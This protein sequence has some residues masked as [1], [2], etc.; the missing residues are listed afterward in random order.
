[1]KGRNGHLDEDQIIAVVV[2]EE[3]L[4]EEQRRH[5]ETCPLCREEKAALASGLDRLGRMAV[6]FTPALQRR[7]SIPA[8]ESRLLSF[9]RMVFATGFAAAL[10]VALIWGPAF[11]SDPTRQRVVEF[12]D[13]EEMD[14][15]LVE[16]ILAESALPDY[17]L[18]MAASSP[19]FFDEEFMELLI[20]SEEYES[21]VGKS[22]RFAK[23]PSSVSFYLKDSTSCFANAC[24]VKS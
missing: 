15:F 19:D 22:R 1:M 20:P 12:S 5:L 6:K 13:D 23:N 3:G 8:R 14:L 7:P 2:D 10:L 21:A 18:D 9:R 16:D 4:K 24:S 11:L 17:Y